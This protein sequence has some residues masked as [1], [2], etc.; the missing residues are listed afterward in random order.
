ME[1]ELAGTL[2]RALSECT[3]MSSFELVGFQ[4]IDQQ[5]CFSIDSIGLFCPTQDAP[6]QWAAQSNEFSNE[7][8]D[9]LPFSTVQNECFPFND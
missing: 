1:G 2:R 8:A 3:A 7:P 4:L 5:I 6:L 9:N